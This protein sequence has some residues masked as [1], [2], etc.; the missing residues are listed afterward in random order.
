MGEFNQYLNGSPK[1]IQVVFTLYIPSLKLPPSLWGCRGV[2]SEKDVKN[3]SIQ[4]EDMEIE[5]NEEEA[6]ILAERSRLMDEKVR[7]KQKRIEEE[8]KL[9]KEKLDVIEMNVEREKKEKKAL[10]QKTKDLNK[11]KKK[12]QQQS[13]K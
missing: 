8:E 9:Q 4:L 6:A 7:A 2:E 3:I 10:R 11:R 13:H 5:N 12:K 1:I